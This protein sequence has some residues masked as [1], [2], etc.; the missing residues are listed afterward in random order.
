MEPLIVRLF[1]VKLPLLLIAD[2]LVKVNDAL[3]VPLI[4]K[5]LLIFK[6]VTA[7]MLPEI[8]TLFS[9]LLAADCN[10]AKLVIGFTVSLDLV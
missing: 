5:S 9:P 2:E 10:S 6:S 3:S 8:V 1:K 7:V 4:V